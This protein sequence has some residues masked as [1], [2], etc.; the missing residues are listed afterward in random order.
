MQTIAPQTLE[1]AIKNGT[2]NAYM[3]SL[4]AE[5]FFQSGEEVVVPKDRL[6]NFI[7]SAKNQLRGRVGVVQYYTDNNHYLVRFEAVGD[8]PAFEKIISKGNLGQPPAEST[9]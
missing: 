4:Y 2:V 8:R 7:R 6:R 1:E 5:P 3:L 9:H